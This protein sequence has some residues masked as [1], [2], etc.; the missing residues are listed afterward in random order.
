MTPL[1]QFHRTRFRVGRGLGAISIVLGLA[2]AAGMLVD[3]EPK[4]ALMPLASVG[5]MLW[6]LSQLP[7]QDAS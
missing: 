4:R 5:F 2:A 3:G 1:N 7:R 6:W